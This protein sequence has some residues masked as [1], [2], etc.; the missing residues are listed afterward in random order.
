VR[1]YLTRSGKDDPPVV[2]TIMILGE[3]KRLAAAGKNDGNL[4]K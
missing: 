3:A 1:L 4:K 2:A